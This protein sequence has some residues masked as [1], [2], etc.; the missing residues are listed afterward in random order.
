MYFTAYSSYI[1]YVATSEKIFVIMNAKAGSAANVGNVRDFLAAHPQI[2]VLEISEGQALLPVAARAIAAN[3]TVLVA[4]G[5]DGTV[6][7]VANAII[8]SKQDVALGIIPL[9]TG[10]D[11]SRCLNIPLDPM[12]AAQCLLADRR[13]RID[14]VE[15]TSSNGQHNYMTNMATGGTSTETTKNTSAKTKQ[16]LKAFSYLMNSWRSLMG[17]KLFKLTVDADGEI[18]KTRSLNVIIANGQTAGGGFVMAPNAKIDDGF[19][20]F[21]S[22]RHSDWK[23]IARMSIKLLWHRLQNDPKLIERRCKSLKID[24]KPGFALSVDGEVGHRT[25]LEFKVLHKALQVIVPLLLLALTNVA[26]AGAA[27]RQIALTFD[28]APRF[29]TSYYSGDDRTF[30]LATKLLREKIEG[31]A[32][33]CTTQYLGEDNGKARLQDYDRL[34]F[35]IANHT[36]TH[37]NLHET[38]ADKFLG[39]AWQADVLLNEFGNFRKWFRFP[40]LNEGETVEKRDYVLKKLN[41]RGYFNAYITVD[42]YDWYLDKLFQEAVRTK[43][44]VHFGRLSQLYVEMI[45]DAVEFYDAIAQKTLGRS[46]K[47]VLLLH[48]NDLAAQFVDRVIK[49]LRRQGWEIISTDEAYTDPIASTPPKTLRTGEGRV[50]GLALDAGYDGPIKGYFSNEKALDKL[51]VDRQIVIQSR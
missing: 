20:D 32:F 49:Q 26:E 19:L 37:P 2:S 38:D 45:V 21:A 30:H 50:A 51:F 10:N 43:Q 48:E 41:E 31:P 8:E 1:S 28:D 14:V 24:A 25:P 39:D 3:A 15:V 42:N 29:S 22:V 47:H 5:G 7:G 18:I 40:Q 13:R 17:L 46:P 23:D 4:A 35:L 27:R 36:H 11:L 16:M 12:Q 9:G 6:A 34:G 44:R 33:F